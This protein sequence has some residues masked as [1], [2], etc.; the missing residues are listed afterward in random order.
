MAAS[1]VRLQTLHDYKARGLLKF[2][3][4]PRLPLTIWN[5][6][7]KAQF[8]RKWDAVTSMCRGLVV[9][10]DE[11]IRARSFNKF[12]NVEEQRH[13]ATDKYEVF[14]KL[15]GSLILLF[16]YDGDWQVASRDSFTSSQA[17]TASE[18]LLGHNL[19]S[20]DTSLTYC[21]EILYAENR[22]V[23]DYQ[24]RRDLVFLAAFRPD[25]TEVPQTQQV[26][27]A[28]FPVVRR[29]DGLDH[30][31]QIK[32]LDWPNSEGFVVRFSNGERVK[33]KFQTY[34]DLQK[35]VSNLNETTVWEWFS[36][37]RNIETTL[38][39][40]PDEWHSWLRDMWAD[41]AMRYAAIVDAAREE[42]AQ[43]EGTPR[44]TAAFALA[45]KNNPRKSLIFML[46]DEKDIHQL[47]CKKIK[48]DRH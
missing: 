15:D 9:D 26:G 4:H 42:A 23:V 41:L 10:D 44:K 3:R 8:S 11:N 28:G 2:Q 45:T 19:D 29:Y 43:L 35:T 5:Y 32:E 12:H 34:C 17:R 25:G 36:S 31:E 14:E 33:V 13:A 48:P 7:E 38:E 22:I 16:Y 37:G 40:V 39:G 24:G 18:I 47:V 1:T 21:F 30:F 27:V 20:L 6:S 46:L